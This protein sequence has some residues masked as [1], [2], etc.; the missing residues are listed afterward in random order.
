MRSMWVGRSVELR[1]GG[2]LVGGC[3]VS[4]LCEIVAGVSLLRRFEA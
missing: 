3:G 1:R 4:L 2:V